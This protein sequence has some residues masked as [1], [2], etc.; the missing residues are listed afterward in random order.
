M[1]LRMPSFEP[2]PL[3]DVPE[4]PSLSGR[5]SGTRDSRGESGALTLAHADDESAEHKLLGDLGPGASSLARRHE[6]RTGI[7][8]LI[9]IVGAAG[10]I[11]YGMRQL[12]MSAQLETLD[13][14]IDYPLDEQATFDVVERERLL[15]D[16]Q[17]SGKIIQV[18]LKDLKMNPFAW[19][20]AQ[21]PQPDEDSSIADAQA[22]AERARIA[23]EKR[24]REIGAAADKLVVRS[25][26]GGKMPIA[27]ISGQIVRAGDTVAEMFTVIEIKARTVVLEVDGRLLEIG[28]FDEE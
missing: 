24:E 11:L 13:L 1:S 19:E 16:L 14:R 7:L 20:A 15:A 27:N 10:G 6:S 8:L 3:P 25:I 12:G 21:S 5:T 23:M 4:V 2:P 17:E 26:M 28:E 9:V 22:A 18:A